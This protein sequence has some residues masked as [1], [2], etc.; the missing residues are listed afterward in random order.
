MSVHIKPATDADR[1][2]LYR[3][4]CKTIRRVIEATWG[5]DEEWQRQDFGRRFNS[6]D[7][8][9]IELDGQARGGLLLEWLPDSLYIHEVQVLPEYQ[10]RGI[11]TTV[12][13]SVIDQASS[14]GVPV[15]LSVVPADPRARNLYERLGFEV[16]HIEPPFIRMQHRGRV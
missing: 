16:T 2:F 3:L 9:I 4:H 8:S 10:G 13:L 7:V 14:R 12:V 15:T 6:Y 1:K 11:G 5:W